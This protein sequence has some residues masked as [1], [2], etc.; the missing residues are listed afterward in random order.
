MN[1][2]SCFLKIMQK[3]SKLYAFSLI[4]DLKVSGKHPFLQPH[5]SYLETLTKLETTYKP[6]QGSHLFGKGSFV[7]F[8]PANLEAIGNKHA[9]SDSVFKVT[10]I[11]EQLDRFGCQL[12]FMY[13]PFNHARRYI[14]VYMVHQYVDFLSRDHHWR[15]L[16]LFTATRKWLICHVNAIDGATLQTTT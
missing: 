3:C 10:R 9:E 15:S 4:I 2:F 8:H 16:I 7:T 5:H 11:I 13:D 6:L 12:E 14:Q 1:I